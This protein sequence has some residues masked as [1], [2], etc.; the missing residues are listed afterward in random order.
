VTRRLTLA[1]ALATCTALTAP[2]AA[3]SISVNN[4]GYSNG[5]AVV[6]V[7]AFAGFGGGSF[8]AGR[9][10]LTT[11][12]DI[13]TA[14]CVDLFRSITI[15][16]QTPPLTYTLGGLNDA[17]TIAASAFTAA[18]VS[19]AIGLAA[20]GN[21]QLAASPGDSAV[22]AAVQGAIWN[23]LFGATVSS[24]DGTVQTLMTQLLGQGFAG[25][26][27]NRLSNLDNQNLLSAQ[28]LFTGGT[29]VPAPAAFGLFGLALAG[30]LAARRRTAA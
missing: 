28:T 22:S 21:A 9:F 2:A 17:P 27:G 23:T 1:I 16:T 20:Y 24:G 3:S 29:A 13:V 11:A 7:G 19:R 12:S 10:A 15:G 30:L 18:Q 26:G 6:S 25:T 4:V 14:W 8:N 5:S